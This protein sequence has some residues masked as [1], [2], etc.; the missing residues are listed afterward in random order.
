M[1]ASEQALPEAERGDALRRADGVQA[2][3][4]V[5][6]QRFKDGLALA[7]AAWQRWQ[8][9]SG[10]APDL[11]VLDLLGAISVA[12]EAGGDMARAS[13]R[14][15]VPLRWPNATTPARIR[16]PPGL[17]GVTGGFLVAQTRYDDAE[18]TSSA[19]SICA[20]ACSAMRTPTR[21]T[22]SPRWAGCAPASS[23]APKRWT[24]S[25]RASPC[26][27]ATRCA[28]T[29]ARACSARTRR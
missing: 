3:A 15:R 12:A 11:A 20:A 26:A 18:P 6:A 4:L 9:E 17:I 1:R 19:P 25:R 22:P 10:A 13:L 28:T 21:S 14:H 7:D 16:A 5:Y 24:G 2:S 23:G 29:S 8:A 27:V